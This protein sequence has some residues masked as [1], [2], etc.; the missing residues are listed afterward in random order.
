MRAL[1]S[2]FDRAITVVLIL[3]VAY[4][5][6]DKFVFDPGRD[7]E[8]IA[9]AIEQVRIDKLVASFGDR[10]IAVLPFVN[11]SNDAEQEYFADGIT[12]ELLNLLAQ[13][14]D[15]RVI[16][17]S[18]AFQYK[19][20]DIHVPSVARELR[21]AHVLEG[22]V[23]RDG[24]MIRITAQLIDA[25]DRHLW[26]DTYDREFSEVFAIQDEIAA[27]VVDSLKL[28][29]PGG[30]PTMRDRDPEAFA[31]YLRAS[32]L[33]NL[34]PDGNTKRYAEEAR[35]LLQEALLRDPGR[36]GHSFCHGARHAATPGH[37]GRHPQAPHADGGA[38]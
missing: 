33:L 4:F 30:A 32:H 28:H 20:K 29:L 37:H 27:K 25:S 26:S 2:R 34:G 13:I 9:A 36:S 8:M 12:E 19:G 6:I 16:S 1:G 17:R 18:S 14:G 24:D 22:S 31:L 35:E 7:E 5:A 23:R 10:S 15:L 3:A 21:V 11:M 38:H